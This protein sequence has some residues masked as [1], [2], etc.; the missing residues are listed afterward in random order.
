IGERGRARR[1]AAVLCAAGGDGRQDTVADDR[2]AAANPIA[3]G[4]AAAGVGDDLVLGGHRLAVLRRRG[5]AGAVPRRGSVWRRGGT[6]GSRGGCCAAAGVRPA[7]C[8]HRGNDARGGVVAHLAHRGGTTAGVDRGAAIGDRVGVALGFRGAAVSAG[9]R[10]ARGY[11]PGLACGVT[12]LGAG[13]RDAVAVGGARIGDGAVAIEGR[14]DLLVGRRRVA[15]E[16]RGLSRS[17][18][19]G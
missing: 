6:G 14:D 2:V 16:G 4:V 5:A 10:A 8:V 19:A 17:V 9:V 3:V 12:D 15:T 11:V 13:K 7:G 1:V 18:G